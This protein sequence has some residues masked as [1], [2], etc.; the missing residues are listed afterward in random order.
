MSVAEANTCW[1]E[2]LLRPMMPIDECVRPASTSHRQVLEERLR[3]PRCDAGPASRAVR[4][5]A[6]L[7]G[8]VPE[9]APGRRVAS[10]HSLTFVHMR[11]ARHTQY[12]RTPSESYNIITRG[13]A[14]CHLLLFWL[15]AAGQG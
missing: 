2:F 13:F 9:R 7:R 8:A 4:G 1:L 14:I 11:V 10:T 3:G 12:R 15:S 5:R 6:R